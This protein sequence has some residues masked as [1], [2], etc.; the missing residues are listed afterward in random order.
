LYALI[1]EL[2]VQPEHM[3]ALRQALDALV[4]MAA[5]EPG[6]LLYAVHGCATDPN[7]LRLYE[8]YADESAFREHLGKPPTRSFVDNLNQWLSTPPCI[9]ASPLLC[10]SH[11]LVNVQ[12]GIS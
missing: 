1:V 2:N 8:L 4:A 12:S 5:G 3:D 6:T 11:Q 7:I 10:L 9:M